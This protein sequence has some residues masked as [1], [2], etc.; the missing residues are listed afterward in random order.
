M[1]S[2]GI[3]IW[4]RVRPLL[5]R[6]RYQ[7]I[8]TVRQDETELN[9]IHRSTSPLSAPS[10]YGRHQSHSKKVSQIE[11]SHEL[12]GRT[13]PDTKDNKA[14]HAGWI[15]G[16]S[17]CAK[18]SAVV[19]MINVLF[20]AIAAGLARNH[21]TEFHF[22]GSLVFY[23]GN[24]GLSKRW[25]VALH[26]VINV[27]STCILAAS[28][29]CMQ[30]LVAP[31][32]EEIDE[33]HDK[34]RWLDIGTASMR[35]LFVIGPRRLALWVILMM[36]A[37]PFHLLYVS[38]RR[39]E[40]ST[41]ISYRYNSMVF[42]AL[43]TNEFGIY[44]GPK[45]LNSQ[46]V[47]NLTTPAVEKCFAHPAAANIGD[48]TWKQFAS[49]IAAGN[50]QNLTSQQCMG[51][52]TKT[53]TAGV[54]ALIALADDLSVNDGGNVAILS[55]GAYGGTTKI[56]EEIVFYHRKILA[57]SLSFDTIVV[58]VP[59][60]VGIGYYQTTNFTIEG[61]Q[62][63]GSS[64]T[65]CSDA[66]E[67]LHWAESYRAD[68]M[69][70]APT[71]AQANEYIQANLSSEIT[72]DHFIDCTGKSPG[73][74]PGNQHTVTKCLAIKANER[75]QLLFSPPIAILICLVALAKVTAMFLA[76]RIGRSRPAPL[77][78][79]GDAVAS[80]MARPDPTTE[81][82]CWVSQGDIKGGTWRRR[83]Q[84]EQAETS[85][86]SSD[87][88]YQRVAVNYRKLQRRKF[89]VQIPSIQRWAITLFLS[90]YPTTLFTTSS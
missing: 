44:V 21:P 76:A 38:C 36:T 23:E 63:D 45:D 29:Y 18:G 90:V 78:T 17:L 20:I 84:I 13:T 54:K 30:T 61:C 85:T 88:G 39:G 47:W 74:F 49:E 69:K 71:I 70:T 64:K 12:L 48:L 67:L 6:G 46:N 35:N 7:E 82:L 25:D 3:R 9:S 60:D 72:Y 79:V 28:N 31:T 58:A 53:N 19:L 33:S 10:T 57:T 81:G 56:A 40:K 62:R 34:Q 1:S 15:A 50:F 66:G 27:L 89:Y 14:Q 73:D 51:L 43:A 8:H 5:S 86:D 68:N 24:C 75:C 4:D 26:L 11:E 87:Q 41:D 55:T 80:F 22:D 83:H 59:R 32:R 42:E 2:Q 77:L 16:V 65:S 37:T 52:T